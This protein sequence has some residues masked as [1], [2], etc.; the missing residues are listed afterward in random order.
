M[1]PIDI[2]KIK[3]EFK[4]YSLSLSHYDVTIKQLKDIEIDGY[5]PFNYSGMVCNK[6]NKP[7]G[8]GRLIETDK[9]RFIDGQFN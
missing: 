3:E 6:T 1:G 4:K 2:D 7:H 5:G 9:Y 8:Y